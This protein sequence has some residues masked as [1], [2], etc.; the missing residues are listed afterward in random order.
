M[1][2][3]L[4]HAGCLEEAKDFLQSMPVQSDAISWI[5][6]LS[7]CKVYG[8]NVLANQC[9]EYLVSTLGRNASSF[10]LTSHAYCHTE[11]QEYAGKIEE[12][13]RSSNAWKKPGVASITIGHRV[14]EFFVEDRN[15]PQYSNIYSKSKR[16]SVHMEE[17]GYVPSLGLILPK[18]NIEIS[19]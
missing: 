18:R 16:L 14:Y 8:D 17:E 19:A 13:R 2:D 5:S 3:L 11:G 1:V 10:L 7:H 9:F 4:G 6:L 12:L 15:H